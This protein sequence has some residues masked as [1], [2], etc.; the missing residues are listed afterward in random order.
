MDWSLYLPDGHCTHVN[1]LRYMPS[2]HTGHAG[3]PAPS[4]HGAHAVLAFAPLLEYL[5]APHEMH[6][7]T[8]VASLLAD[9]LPALHLVHVLSLYA[10]VVSDHVPAPHDTH[11]LAPGAAPH[12]PAA[13]NT[14]SSEVVAP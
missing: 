6:V 8:D 1:T 3:S 4:P 2:A 12:L 10:P 14:H 9:H 5:P 11:E 13:H 7:S